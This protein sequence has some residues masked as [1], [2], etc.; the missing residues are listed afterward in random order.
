[1]S[2]LDDA[3]MYRAYRDFMHT[4]PFDLHEGITVQLNTIACRRIEILAQREAII[5]PGGM[6]QPFAMVMD[7]ARR[8]AHQVI[9][10]TL[11]AAGRR[12]DSAD[13]RVIRLIS[14]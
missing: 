10:S 8:N 14:G 1:M 12:K 5:R 4:L 2:R 7:F 3:C 11:H 13:V 6:T 9:R